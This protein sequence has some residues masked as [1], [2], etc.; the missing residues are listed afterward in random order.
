MKVI[1]TD[2]NSRKAFDIINILK[3]EH[4]YDLLLFSSSGHRF[5]L[6]VLYKQKVY[7]LRTQGYPEFRSDLLSVLEKH[8][9]E[10]YV[11]IPVS[12]EPTLHFYDFIKEDFN[13][14][15]KYLLP[16]KEV[17][18]L[19]RDKKEFQSFCESND[20][21]VPASYNQA[22]LPN[23]EEN[24]QPVIAK[25]KI[26]AGSVGMKYIE[27]PGQ[28]DQL[29]ELDDEEY[30]IQEK[31]E[32]SNKIHGGF[33]LCEDG[34]VKVY[35][36]H[37]RIRTF[38]EKGGVTVFSK[39]SYSEELK[40]IGENLLKKLSWNGFAMVEYLYDDNSGEWKI[41]ELNP[42]LWGSI[43]LSEFCQSSMLS[44][45]IM[46][47]R[48]E[49]IEPGVIET[50]RYIRWL[51]PFELISL[52]KGKLSLGD[53]FNNS[54]KKVCYINVTYSSWMSSFLFHLYFTFNGRSIK[55]FFKKIFS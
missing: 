37:E 22:T 46:L 12:E 20:L 29:R 1:I 3:R 27:E 34:D 10:E 36:G 55:R 25:L 41:I 6:P 44:K 47:A 21:P 7:R 11:Y 45:Y 30:L 32:S 33:Y 40:N 38:P 16:D 9:E 18:E 51:F 54:N 50:D 35:H 17:F 48:N 4:Q 24:F 2:A 52:V 14:N 19:V 53:F 23:L 39:A 26:G 8:R 5:Q 28:L 43:M 31:V 49:D 13:F 15:I 42:R